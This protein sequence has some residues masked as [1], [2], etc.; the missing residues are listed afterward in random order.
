MFLKKIKFIAYLFPFFVYAPNVFGVKDK[1]GR[2][3][4]LEW[5][6]TLAESDKNVSYKSY[7][8]Q[9]KDYKKFEIN[10]KKH[11]QNFHLDIENEI[12]TEKNLPLNNSER[13]YYLMRAKHEDTVCGFAYFKKEEIQNK[14]SFLL[15]FIALLPEYQGGGI[16]KYLVFGIH[17]KFPETTISLDVRAFNT[18]A[19]A[20]YE[21]L[22]F[23]KKETKET[24]YIRYVWE[25]Q[26]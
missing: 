24:G 26:L 11:L 5:D 4:N 1:Q 23:S 8:S 2:E 20:F 22:G 21:H 25:K 6:S 3:I 7:A 16:G 15:Q 18:N 14:A 10:L 19:Q 9:E 17:E 12:E 13:K